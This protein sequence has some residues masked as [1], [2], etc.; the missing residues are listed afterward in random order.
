[1]D[2]DVAQTARLFFKEFKNFP[3]SKEPEITSP[4]STHRKALDE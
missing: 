4:L 3:R 2:I 1:L